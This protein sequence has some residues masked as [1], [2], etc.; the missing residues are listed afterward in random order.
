[1]VV[2]KKR[3]FYLLESKSGDVKPLISEQMD[4]KSTFGSIESY[5][6]RQGDAS[7]LGPALK[8]REQA[9]QETDPHSLMLVLSIATAFIPVVGPLVS[10]GV[11][12]ADAGMYASEGDM[13]NA[14]LNVMFALLPGI[15]SIIKKIPAINRLGKKGMEILANK[16]SK[17]SKLTQTETEVINGIKNNIEFVNQELSTSVRNT[18]KNAANTTVDVGLKSKLLDIAKK[19]LTYTGN[20]ASKT[21]K[22]GVKL[23]ASAVPYVAADYAYGKTYDK[24]QSNT[25]SMKT[26]NEEWD[27][28]TLKLAFGSSGSAEENLMLQKA[29][30]EGW[31]PGNVVPEKYRTELYKKNYEE[32][33]ESFKELSSIIE[34]ARMVNNE[35]Q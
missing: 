29:Y 19:G 28:N 14:G 2:D 11:M 12:L 8:R 20:V 6:Y 17:N 4:A 21:A 32:D 9:L 34:K 30:K 33:I 27:W 5:G 13:K 10:A 23:V 15:G 31:R 26:K 18:A 25:P 22:S 1:M 35:N 16:L 3:F 7:T 24:L